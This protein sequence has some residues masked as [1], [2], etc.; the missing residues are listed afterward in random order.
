MIS[1]YQNIHLRNVEKVINSDPVRMAE[2][3]KKM[4][5]EE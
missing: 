2:M 1:W 4:G 3:V 5:F